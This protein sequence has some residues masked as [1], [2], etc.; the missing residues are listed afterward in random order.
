VAIED[1]IR[2]EYGSRT[3]A[4]TLR[5]ARKATKKTNKMRAK[6]RKDKDRLSLKEQRIAMES[7]R[8]DY[9][10]LIDAGVI[11]DTK[12]GQALIAGNKFQIANRVSERMQD[13]SDR[14]LD[15]VGAVLSKRGPQAKR[16]Y[17]KEREKIRIRR[18]KSAKN[19]GLLGAVGIDLSARV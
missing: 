9:R 1:F 11:K 7:R 14:Q 15:V 12:S 6:A 16:F 4:G 5:E 10:K 8:A 19:T 2:R 3:S 17:E 18:G 13:L